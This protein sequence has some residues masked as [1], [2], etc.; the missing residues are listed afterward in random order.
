VDEAVER[1]V[2]LLIEMERKGVGRI[3]VRSGTTKTRT[4]KAMVEM[5]N[6]LYQNG[7]A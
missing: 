7:W 4:Y 2:S 1:R 3:R 6:L 5:L